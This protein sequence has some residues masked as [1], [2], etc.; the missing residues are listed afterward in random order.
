MIKRWVMFVAVACAVELTASTAVE[1]P[2]ERIAAAVAGDPVCVVSNVSQVV[3]KSKKIVEVYYI[4]KPGPGSFIRCRVAMPDK[5]DWTGRMWGYGRG[6]WAGNDASYVPYAVS[7]DAAV[8]CDMGT[9]RSTG[10]TRKHH[11]TV[12]NED[13]W[14]DFSWRSTHLMT[15]YAKKF[16][17]AFYG[18]KV[19]K[20]Y[21]IGASTGGGQGMHE[22]QRFPEDYDGI[23]AQLPANSRVSLEASA[24]HRVKLAPRLK[25]DNKRKK[26][27]ADAPVKFMADKD[28]ENVRGKYLSDPR[29]CDGHEEA[30]FDIAGQQDPVFAEP[31]VRDALRELFSGV[32]HRGRRAHHGYCWG[33]LFAGESGLFLFKN[34]YSRKYARPFDAEKATWD[35]FDEF[36]VAHKADINATSADLSSFADRG[37]KIIMTIGLEDQTIPFSSAIDAYEETA[38][39]MGGIERLRGFYR[40]YLMPGCAHGNVGREM[41]SCPVQDLKR[42]IVDWVEKGIAP[43]M[44]CPKTRE[45][46]T[47]KIPPYPESA[48]DKGQKRDM[49]RGGVRRLHPFYR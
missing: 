23:I 8:S 15:V 29:N 26:I 38:S 27:L 16:C 43:D 21:F 25:L 6:G 35:D 48:F 46:D 36:V 10:W 13:E 9:G 5:K 33:A 30:I 3:I 40:M 12:W 34:F 2:E 14:K 42:C 39:H 11:P 4:L 44:I 20:A 28:V 19:D 17:E 1:S 45:G 7:G 18:R 41:Q 49:R 47:L 31:D 24:F 22:A 32:V 37:G